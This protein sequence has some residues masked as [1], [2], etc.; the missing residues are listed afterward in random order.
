MHRSEQEGLLSSTRV[1]YSEGAP[2]EGVLVKGEQVEGGVQVASEQ[3][4]VDAPVV[5]PAPFRF[6]DLALPLALVA[7]AVFVGS[8]GGVLGQRA[9]RESD[10]SDATLGSFPAVGLVGAAIPILSLG[11]Y[12]IMG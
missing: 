8:V 9:F 11:A 4:V 12:V 1:N 2:V 6:S 5:A 7:L 10:L 3:P